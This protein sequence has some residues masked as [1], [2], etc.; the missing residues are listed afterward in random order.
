M[1]MLDR[2]ITV[3]R[4]QLLPTNYRYYSWMRIVNK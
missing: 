4:L 3:V 1:N 2:K